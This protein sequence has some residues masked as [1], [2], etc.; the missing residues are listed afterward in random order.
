M[1]GSPNIRRHSKVLFIQSF[2][3]NIQNVLHGLSSNLSATLTEE[4]RR[5]IEVNTLSRSIAI[6]LQDNIHFRCSFIRGF[7]NNRLSSAKRRWFMVGAE[8]ATLI[9]SRCDDQRLCF[10]RLE[11]LSATSKKR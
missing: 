5:F 4:N 10:R 1:L 3:R 2:I 11:R 6:F 9:P 7:T 8:E